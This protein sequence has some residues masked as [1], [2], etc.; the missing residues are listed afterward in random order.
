MRDPTN[1][2]TTLEPQDQEI[3]KICEIQE[4]LSHLASLG[5]RRRHPHS[6]NTA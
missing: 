4:R 6:E 3:G 5:G 1:P 2:F